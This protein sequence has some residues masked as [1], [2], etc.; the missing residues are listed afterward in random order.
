[1]TD[2]DLNIDD[3]GTITVVLQKLIKQLPR[4]IELKDYVDQGG[5]LSELDIQFLTRVLNNANHNAH[6]LHLKDHP[7]LAETATKITGLYEAI[8]SKALENETKAQ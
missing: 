5:C 7:E 1:M 8:T 3:D 2:N 4:L 6:H